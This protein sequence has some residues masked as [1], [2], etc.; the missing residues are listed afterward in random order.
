MSIFP[1]FQLLEL[2]IISAQDLAPVSRKMKT[3]AVAWVHSERKLTTRVDYTGGGNPTWNDKF[4]FR[5]SEDFLYAD[6][7]AVVVEIYALHWFR[8]VHVGTVR[9]LISNLIPPNRRP[10]YRSNEEYRR[11]PP[12]GMRFVALQVRR[13]SGR[14]Q[15]ILNI[16]V[17]ILDG[18][19]RSMPLYTNMD[20]SA[21]GYRDLLGEED[22]NLQNLHLNS[23][24]GSSKNPQSPSSKQYQSVVS[25]PPMLRRTRSDTSSM[26]VSDLLS[27]VERSRVA[28]RKPASALMS[29]ESETVPTTTGHD[30]VTS[31][32][33]L[34][35]SI[36]YALPYQSPKIPSQGYD[37]YEPDFIDQSPNH[38]VLRPR[39]ERQHEPDFI[40][41]SPFRSN[42][43]SRKTP[44]RSTPMIEKPR[45]PRDYDRTSSRASPY[46]SRHGTPLRSNIVASTPIRSNMVSSSPMRSTGVGSTPRR[47]NILGSTPLRS[48]IVGSTPIRSNYK[49]TP[50]KSPMQF[51][52]PMR[53]NLAGRPVLTESELGPSPSEVAQKMAKERSQAYETESSILSEWSLDDDSNIEGL[54]SKLERWRTELPPLY[55]LGSSHQS[56]DVGSGAMVVANV[57]GGKSSRKKT[58]AVKKKH[59]RRHT[60]GGGNGL[61]SC[62]SNLCGV[63]CTFVCG[64]GS[65][66]D[67]SKKKGGSGRLP[68][69]EDS[70]LR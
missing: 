35:K 2:N 16:G 55:D 7:S 11:T 17:G 36:E 50:M 42:D 39:S 30:S 22:P 68:R 29:A 51:G 45:P 14:P 28:N 24:K 20:S 40:D 43:R 26:V 4:V 5:V 60:E 54:R 9:V 57:G 46:L 15:G 6:T 38:N 56:S 34:T 37:S 25:R 13:P 12:P 49:A 27:R 10:G 48:N 8:D 3:Y 59:N 47:S 69:F 21:V 52:T 19:M 65:D 31:D 32:S 67:G 63:E 53:S 70:D 61:F 1:S 18:S 44:R 66:Q 33:E 64:G 23:F 58:P 62:F 41:Q